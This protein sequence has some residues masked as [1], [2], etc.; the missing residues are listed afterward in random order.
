MPSILEHPLNSP[1]TWKADTLLDN[2]G[3]VTIDTACKSELLALAKD[4]AANPLPTVALDPADFDLPACRAL[5]SQVRAILEEGIGFAIID[6]LP[7]DEVDVE[8]AKKLYWILM[9]MIGKAVAQKWDGT[10]LYDVTD[11]KQKSLAGSGVRSSKTNGGQDYHTDNAFNLPPDYVALMCLQPAMEGG[12][13]GL[14][15]FESAYNLMLERHPD[16]IARLYEPFYFDRQREHAP[17]DNLTNFKP[18]LTYDG[19]VLASNFSPRLVHQGY[20]MEGVELDEAGRQA[21]EA[22]GEITEQDGLGKTFVFERGQIQIVNNRQLGH[23]RTAYTDWPDEKDKRHLV[24]IWLRKDGRPF[25]Q[26]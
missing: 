22:F 17:D 8:T 19:K 4:L 2:D 10:L 15:S 12:V 26:G 3:L 5:T 25:Y 9:S 11:T 7:L 24:R 21:L 20:A 6:K 16:K 18:V 23:R 13:S 1:M 14:V